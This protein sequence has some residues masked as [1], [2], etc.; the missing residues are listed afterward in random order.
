M[1]GPQ[2]LSNANIDL[3]P[4]TGSAFL[5]ILFTLNIQTP[6][7]PMIAGLLAVD[8]LGSFSVAGATVMF[9]LG[10]TFGGVAHPWSSAVVLCLLIFGAALFIVFILI[11]WKVAKYP[12][13]PLRLYRNASNMA[14]LASCFCHGSILVLGAFFLPLYFQA[15]LG[16]TALL[17]GVWLLPFALSMSFSAGFTGWYIS[18]TGRYIDGVRLAFGLSVLGFGLL[19]NLTSQKSWPKI[20]IFQI[21]CGVGIGPNFQALLI[22]LQSQVEP[23][24]YATATAAFGFMRNLATSIGLVIG[25][26]IFQN[27][28]L[29][30][31][32]ILTETLGPQMAE[33]FY[34]GSAEASVHIADALPDA[35]KAVV[36]NAYYT[37]I[38]AVWFLAVAFAG[39][40]LVLILFIRVKE[41]SRIH[42]QIKTGL[43]SMG[44]PREEGT[45]RTPKQG[46]P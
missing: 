5:I 24:D 10:L 42:E 1:D 41:L 2:F 21:I 12:L 4:V 29:K 11:E 31:S 3:V 8:W 38:R 23:Q 6:K 19:I 46:E 17:S 13:M 35:Q 33:L 34:G 20:I 7:T 28:M 26:V 27:R 44:P 36:R 16:A 25:N 9:L 40:G 18:A 37:S 32:A 39:A 15:T 22:A 30:R 45:I 43:E 14:S